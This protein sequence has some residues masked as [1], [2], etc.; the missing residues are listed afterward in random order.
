MKRLGTAIAMVIAAASACAL[1]QTPM[2]GGTMTA[3]APG[4]GVAVNTVEVTAK[5]EAVDRATRTVTLKAADGHERTITVGPEVKNFKHIKVGDLVAV[6]YVEALTLELKKGGK[7]IVARTDSMM[8]AKA[9][10]GE[11]PAAGVG[12]QVHVTADVVAVDPA[13]QTVT[14]RGP[15]RTVD[16]KLSDPEQFKLVSVGDQVDATYTEAMAISVEPS[17]GMK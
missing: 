14:L 2:T 13:T 9:K 16:L 3:T 17:T 8:G 5:V 1:A 4:K 6:R 11:K 10:P 7:A 12:R 15:K